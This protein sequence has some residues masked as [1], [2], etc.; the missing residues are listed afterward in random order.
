MYCTVVSCP[1]FGSS[2]IKNYVEEVAFMRLKASMAIWTAHTLSAIQIMLKISPPAPTLRSLTTVKSMAIPP[3]KIPTT[4]SG[5]PKSVVNTLVVPDATAS[6]AFSAV[7]VDGSG[8]LYL[9]CISPDPIPEKMSARIASTA[10]VLDDPFAGFFVVRAWFGVFCCM[11]TALQTVY[12]KSS[13]C[14][15]WSS[16]L[17][18]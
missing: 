15:E 14:L 12:D 17:E 1:L 10:P 8:G 2:E 16:A 5:Y 9:A 4:N 7:V 11:V 3:R 6:P 13:S 18:A